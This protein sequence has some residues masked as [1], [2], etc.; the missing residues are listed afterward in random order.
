MGFDGVL[1]TEVVRIGVSDLFEL[2][3][4]F[5][6]NREVFGRESVGVGI[7]GG[8]ALPFQGARSSGLLRVQLIRAEL[9]S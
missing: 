9:S 1:R 2:G 7:H 8:A 4:F 5:R 6:R 3:S